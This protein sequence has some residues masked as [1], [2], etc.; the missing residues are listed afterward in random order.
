MNQITKF[1]P[2]KRQRAYVDK[3]ESEVKCFLFKYLLLSSVAM[4][5]LLVSFVYK[6]RLIT[7]FLALIL[8]LCFLP[9]CYFTVLY[10]AFVERKGVELEKIYKNGEIL[11]VQQKGKHYVCN[12]KLKV[13]KFLEKKVVVE[14]EQRE[15]EL[16]INPKIVKL[17]YEENQKKDNPYSIIDGLEP[18]FDINENTIVFFE[19]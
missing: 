8:V 17:S 16:L 11:F 2:L 12:A 19:G 10:I 4:L 15:F 1:I 6:H 13:S 18:F 14:W 7:F 5:L 9:V 3:L